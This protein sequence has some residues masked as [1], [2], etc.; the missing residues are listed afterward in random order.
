MIP[1][2]HARKI[3]SSL[4][5][6]ISFFFF[7]LWLFSAST[8]CFYYFNPDSPQSNM[9]RL[10]EAMDN[11][12]AF[13]NIPLVFQPFTKLSDFDR[14]VREEAPDFL[15]LPEWYLKQDGNEKRFEAFL[16]PVRNGNTT[17]RKI[18]LVAQDSSL[19]IQ[20]LAQETIAMTPMGAAGLEDLDKV[21]FQKHGLDSKKLNFVTTAKDSDALFALALRQ[22]KAALV[23]EDNLD[24]FGAIN[25]R[26][27]QTVKQLAI[28]DPIPLPL[29]CYNKEIAGKDE[30]EKLKSLFLKGKIDGGTAKIMEM[31]HIDAWQTIN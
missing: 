31:L 20:D 27:L 30:V 10:K 7:P 19:S 1:I 3:I 13:G 21:I 26:I 23:S 11:L 2:K 15:L 22:V 9:S 8:A 6:P 18:L 16:A 12:L 4:F 29:L 5:V 14:K 17:Y 25:P 24:H 28:S